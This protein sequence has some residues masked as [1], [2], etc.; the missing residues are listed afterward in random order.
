MS[1]RVWQQLDALV[2]R[3]QRTAVGLMA[4]TSL[5]GIDAA[6][7]A[8]EGFGQVR[9]VRTLATHF[10]PYT[11]SEREGLLTLIRRGELD[12]LTAWDAYLGERFA[13]AAQRAIQ[14]AGLP[15]VDFI[16]S[17]GQTVWHAPDAQLFRRAVPNT[18]QIGQPDVIA[19]RLGVPVVADFRTRDMAYGGQGAPLV[20]FVDWLLLRDAHEARATLNL[21][22][23][24]NLTLLP[25]GSS[26][27]AI[28]AFDTGPGNALIDLAVRW[29]T[30]G[31]EAYDRDGARAA[32]GQVI[33]ELLAQLLMHPFFEQPPPKSTGREMFGE[34]LLQEIWRQYP[35]SR[36]NLDDLVATLTELTARTVA[37]ALRRWGLSQMP[38]QRLLVSGGGIHNRTLIARLQALLPEVTIE[39]TAAYGID[40]DFKE[41]I[42]FALLADCF[43]QG[44]PVAYPGITGVAQP[45]R[46][47][48]LCWG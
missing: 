20:P 26:P 38:V 47:G 48:K 8:I 13:E 44:E 12:A 31:R 4:G 27:D 25:A 11:E 23:M 2:Q 37:D 22:G 41:A 40:P 18:L 24:A 6:V 16:G 5:D 36:A 42:A 43:L 35:P 17:H 14:K 15:S 21:G 33:P 28:L 46:L 19:A 30:E 10:E 29:G 45:V 39:S 3:A 9:Q 7:V 1:T 34:S 32:R